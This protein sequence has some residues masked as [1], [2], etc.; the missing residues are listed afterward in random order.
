MSFHGGRSPVHAIT[1]LVLTALLALFACQPAP[2][3]NGA[4]VTPTA[5][6]EPV[7]AIHDGLRVTSIDS[8]WDGYGEAVAI[9]G[10]VAVIGAS[11]WNYS[12]DGY[13][14]VYRRVN[15]AWQ[16]EAQLA[17][18]DR[19]PVPPTEARG[20][21]GQRFGSAVALGD[22]MLVVGAP[23]TDSAFGGA[24]YVYEY[25]GQ[26]WTETAKLVPTG[27]IHY[28]PRT[29]PEWLKSG[30]MPR[31]TFGQLLALHGD[32][33]AV[34]GDAYAR[35][36]TIFTRAEG[37]W[38]QSAT[39]D[40]PARDDHELY[41]VSMDLFGDTLAL[42][43]YYVD[44]DQPDRNYS[45]LFNGQS[46][47]YLYER[48]DGAWHQPLQVEL[49]HADALFNR[50]ARLGPT[51]AL[52]GSEGRATHLAVGL[53]GFPDLSAFSDLRDAPMLVGR[54]AGG[55]E[56]EEPIPGYPPS[57]HQV[58]TVTILQRVADGDWQQQAVLTP[59]TG[60]ALPQPGF[61]FVSDPT[62]LATIYEPVNL[63]RMVFPGHWYSSDPATTFFGATVD[64]DG[65]RLAV[66]SG[67]ANATHVFQRQEDGGWRYLAY[68]QSGDGEVTEDYAQI[69]ALS[70]DTVL[71]GTPGEFGNSAVFFH[72]P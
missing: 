39:I 62:V 32:T 37:S 4:A 12:G 66:T 29:E 17:A 48:R 52:E 69:V 45:S 71:L 25:N 5:F 44:H 11:E 34:G 1:F 2:G 3:Q 30:R 13:A 54:A 15:G 14:Y 47:V 65:D 64:L 36:V 67:F 42:G 72:V 7:T 60:E 55:V 24:V 49:E 46:A 56:H 8:E 21:K 59:A 31:R 28:D 35:T 26:S 43:V 18:S 19:N 61:L 16:E 68:I 38:Q 51:V 53:P 41:M 10:D 57:P 50:E 58:G 33:L 9:R 63:S 27:D 6:D 20:L 22:G 23:G 70:G 40:I